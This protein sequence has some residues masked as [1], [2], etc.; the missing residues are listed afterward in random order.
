M[1]PAGFHAVQCCPLPGAISAFYPS[2]GNSDQEKCDWSRVRAVF[3]SSL[4]Q[5]H[6]LFL[7]A[8]HSL[9]LLLCPGSSLW[10]SFPAWLWGRLEEPRRRGRE[11]ASSSRCCPSVMLSRSAS[12]TAGTLSCTK[13]PEILSAESVILCLRVNAG[14]E[15]GREYLSP[16]CTS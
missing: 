4:T 2:T 7:S 3:H 8:F 16:L 13:Q 12:R 5:F 9:S 11:P 14:R 15:K 10:D 6:S 1:L